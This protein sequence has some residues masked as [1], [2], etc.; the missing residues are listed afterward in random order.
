M[1]I[2]KDCNLIMRDVYLYDITS[3]HYSILQ[4]MGFDM[5]NINKNNK[6]ERNI[7]IGKLMQKNSRLTSLLRTTTESIIDE[8]LTIN[9]VKPEEIILRQYDG[10]LVTRHLP[11]EI[12]QSIQLDFRS[13]FLIFISSIERD[14][15]ISTDGKKTTIKGVPHKYENLNNIYHMI[16]N[17]EYVRG[18]TTIFRSLQKIKDSFFKSNDTSLFCIPVDNDK[19]KVFLKG[20]GEI[21][22]SEQTIKIMD[23]E[24]IDKE[25]YFDF[26]FKPFTTSIT[27]EFI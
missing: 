10:V 27:A 17:I 9:N 23:T 8:Y 16:A 20:Y 13:H 25:W 24:D 19:Y 5:V 2:N 12:K 22:I 15:Y 14:K 1:K 7:Q 18:K 3:C 4:N 21:E 6:L 26:Y 11:V